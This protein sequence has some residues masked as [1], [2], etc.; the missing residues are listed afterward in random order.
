MS[1]QTTVSPIDAHGLSSLALQMAWSNSASD[2]WRQRIQKEQRGEALGTETAR[3]LEFFHT[4]RAQNQPL[5]MTLTSTNAPSSNFSIRNL[6]ATAA[7]ATPLLQPTPPP[8]E[9]ASAHP[10]RPIALSSTAPAGFLS[11]SAP[12]ASDSKDVKSM[13]LTAG[14]V[15][16]IFRFE[17]AFL[18]ALTQS[19]SF[20]S[21]QLNSARPNAQL[22]MEPTPQTEAA[23]HASLRPLDQALSATACTALQ[24]TKPREP[25]SGSVSRSQRLTSLGMK[26]SREIL[27]NDGFSPFRQNR[28]NDPW[29][30]GLPLPLL[31]PLSSFFW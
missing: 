6:N 14:S 17:L 2:F 20:R 8:S 15:C 12:L 25:L 24:P 9:P 11:Q 10:A 13:S 27:L 4:Q 23:L 19:Y 26:T 31:P 29:S 1:P 16:P 18:L 30:T 5:Q 3:R 7:P 21:A 22:Y 28:W